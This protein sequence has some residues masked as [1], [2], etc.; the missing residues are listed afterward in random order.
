M[1]CEA[2][3]SAD[4]AAE[5]RR[6]AVQSLVVAG[7]AS[8]ADVEE[9]VR[10]GDRAGV[11]L[12][13]ALNRLGHVRDLEL[14]RALADAAK[15]PFRSATDLP[16]VPPLVE[17]VSTAFLDAHEAVILEADEQRVTLGLVDP[18]DDAAIRGV[19]F[20]CRRHVEAV[21]VT[22]SDRRRLAAAVNPNQANLV[23]AQDDEAA[24]AQLVSHYDAPVAREVARWLASAI[25]TGSSDVHIEPRERELA[26]RVRRD[27]ALTQVARAP[28]EAAA[29]VIARIKVLADLDLGERRKDQDGRARVVVAGR[30]VDLRVSIVPSVEGESAAIRILDKSSVK[31]DFEE[32]GFA[33]NERRIFE[34]MV[35]ASH[36]LYLITGP[37]GSGKTTT[38]YA[39]LEAMRESPRKILTVEDPVEFRFEHATQI[40]TSAKAGVTFAGSVR[41]FLRQDPDVI[42]IGEIRDAET[43]RA[44]VE[45]ALTGHLVLAT[46]HA[47]DAPGVAPRLIDMGVESYRLAATLKGAVAQRLVRRLCDSCR[48]S[49]EARA[50]EVSFLKLSSPA[51]RTD[52]FEPVGCDRCSGTGFVGRTVIA[53]GFEADA[54]FLDAARRGGEAEMITAAEAAMPHRLVTD[55]ALKVLS[56]ATTADEVVRALA[57]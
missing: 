5:E 38:L 27:G 2:I 12:A 32:L 29:G 25:E 16:S 10:A 13:I 18:F 6:R 20:A 7:I 44:A 22:A 40:Q 4:R 14:A 37:T 17:G 42:L 30:P 9:A 8:A 1:T 26:I 31:L 41:S 23:G 3:V 33:A 35:H 39:G 46:V 19:A 56:G 53:E 36:G 11:G 49:R 24:E 51:N 34:R 28:K 57:S 47:V 48:R 21:V 55:G 15:A 54:R 43:A 52:V 50:D 45:A